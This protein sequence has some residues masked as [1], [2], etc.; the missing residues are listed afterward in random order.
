VRSFSGG[1]LG[2]VYLAPGRSP[3][4]RVS[5]V[6]VCTGLGG[7]ALRQ[8]RELGLDCYI[9][10]ENLAEREETGAPFVIETGHTLSERCGVE[11]VR[12][13]LAPLGVEVDI[14][15]LGLDHYSGEVYG[16]DLGAA[17]LRLELTLSRLGEA[18]ERPRAPKALIAIVET[19]ASLLSVIRLLEETVGSSGVAARGGRPPTVEA[20]DEAR[21]LV[22]MASASLEDFEEMSRRAL[23][24]DEELEEDLATRGDDGEPPQSASKK[25]RP[26]ARRPRGPV[27][28]WD[29]R[30][31]LDISR[32]ALRLGKRQLDTVLLL[33]EVG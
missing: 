28:A 13:A 1:V 15:P 25:P 5:R 6:G 7:L 32:E 12:A 21:T 18:S 10:G 17:A 14:A 8:V 4:D 20:L 30:S 23:K 16:G 26:R 11:F 31:A 22:A 19:G 3:D 29:L 27:Y 33:A 24:K 2:E 9:T